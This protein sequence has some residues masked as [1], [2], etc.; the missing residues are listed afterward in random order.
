MDGARRQKSAKRASWDSGR[1][2]AVRSNRGVFGSDDGRIGRAEGALGRR[3]AGFRNVRSAGFFTRFA[4]FV[5]ARRLVFLR[6]RTGFRAF[7]RRLRRGAR[8]A[9]LARLLAVRERGDLVQRLAGVAGNVF[10]NAD[11][12]VE[13]AGEA[14]EHF[15]VGHLNFDQRPEEIADLARRRPRAVALGVLVFVA[16]VV[17]FVVLRHGRIPLW[18]TGRRLAPGD[19][20]TRPERFLARL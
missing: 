17:V 11:R 9:G 13:L 1:P 15:V 4:G 12:P 19:I 6:R 3:A 2:E 5:L 10:E 14:G 7:R 8:F 18:R 16:L 20:Q